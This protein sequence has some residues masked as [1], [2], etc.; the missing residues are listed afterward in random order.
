MS[1]WKNIPGNACIEDV[2]L[3]DGEWKHDGNA[4]PA[5]VQP[6]LKAAFPDADKDT[7][8]ELDI[9]FSSSGYYDAGRVSGPPEDCYP[10]EGEDERTLDCITV[11]GPGGSGVKFKLEGKVADAV[12]DHFFDIVEEVELD[13]DRGGDDDIDPPDDDDYDDPAADFIA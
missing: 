3:E 13:T 11:H 10:P 5:A 7:S 1:H 12:F 2:C 8:L 4:L 9:E 6:I